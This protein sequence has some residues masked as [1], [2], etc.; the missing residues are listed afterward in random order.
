MSGSF[1]LVLCD[2]HA[3]VVRAW[4]R[5]FSSFP[6]V[7]IVHG[8]LIDVAA[9]AYVSPANSLGIMDGG[10]DVALRDRFPLVETRVQDAIARGG[11]PLRV[12]ECLVVETGDFDVPYL[13]CAPTTSLPGRAAS[14]DHALLAMRAI[15]EAVDR[16][17]EQKGEITAVAVPGL[18]TGIGEMSPEVSASQMADAYRSWLEPLRH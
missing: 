18:C 11:R 12:G 5:E 9:D 16:F 4:W 3:P 14:S 13:L 6:E 10:I 8:N 15:L 2:L 17:N 1:D 7:E